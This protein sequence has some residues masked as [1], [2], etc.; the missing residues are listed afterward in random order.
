MEGFMDRP[1]PFETF[2]IAE[3]CWL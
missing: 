2:L 1:I 3:V